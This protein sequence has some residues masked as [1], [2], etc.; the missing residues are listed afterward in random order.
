MRF[1]FGPVKLVLRQ[2]LCSSWRTSCCRFLTQSWIS[3]LVEDL[4]TW[5]KAGV[6]C[7]VARPHTNSCRESKSVFWSDLVVHRVFRLNLRWIEKNLV[8]NIMQLRAYCGCFFF[9]KLKS[10]GNLHCIALHNSQHWYNAENIFITSSC[11]ELAALNVVFHSK[12]FDC[13]INLQTKIYSELITA[14]HLL[15]FFSNFFVS[16]TLC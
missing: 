10:S 7:G 8:I 13:F 4:A 16:N 15:N 1:T 12:V 11:W 6:Q 14:E 9:F 2:S 5:T 3:A